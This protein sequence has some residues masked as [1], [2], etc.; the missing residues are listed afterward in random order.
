M[1]LQIFIYFFIYFIYQ[2]SCLLF[3]YS[4]TLCSTDFCIWLPPSWYFVLLSISLYWYSY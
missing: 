2:A 3:K 1:K 4:V